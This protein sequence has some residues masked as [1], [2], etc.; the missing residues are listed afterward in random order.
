MTDETTVDVSAVVAEFIERGLSLATGESLTAGLLASTIAE[1]PG[2]SAMFRGAIVAYQVDLKRELLAVTDAE[3]ER[4]VVSR[5]V[6]VAMARGA[7]RRLHADVGVGT[8]GVAGPDTL[9]GEP[10]GS[11]WIAVTTAAGVRSS[12]LQIDADRAVVRRQTVVACLGL[13]WEALRE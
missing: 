2:C 11:V 9:D 6:A 1:V 8:T 5:E 10:A 3:L 7:A 13:L 4:G 12:H